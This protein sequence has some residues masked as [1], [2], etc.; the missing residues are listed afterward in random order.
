MFISVLMRM[1]VRRFVLFVCAQCAWRRTH[2]FQ[3]GQL[4][5]EYSSIFE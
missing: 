1:L 4:V 3:A 2:E 5:F